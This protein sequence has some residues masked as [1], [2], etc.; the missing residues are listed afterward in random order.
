MGRLPLDPEMETTRV[1][2]W[3]KKRPQLLAIRTYMEGTDGIRR[4]VSE[5]MNDMIDI[6]YAHMQNREDI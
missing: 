4:T 1:Y 2:I 3:E 6:F 5:A